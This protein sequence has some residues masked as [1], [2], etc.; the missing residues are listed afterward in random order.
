MNPEKVIVPDR[1]A[2]GAFS[3]DRRQFLK[4]LGGGI[5]ICFTP[6]LPNL[7]NETLAAGPG[8]LPKD[9]NA[10]LRINEDGR[11]TLF[12]GKIEMGQGII[13]SLAQMLAEE[14]DVP[15]SSVDMVMGDTDLCPWDAGTYGSMSTK[16]F[17][18]PLRD[19]AAEARQIL[20]LL[21]SQ[22]L[23]VP[24]DRLETRA[25]S[26]VDKQAPKRGVTYGAL[27]KGKRIEKHLDG[28]PLLKPWTEFT[29]S[30]KPTKRTDAVAKVTGQA[31]FT[32]DFTF[33]GMLYAKILRPPV[34]GAK[35]MD[36]DTSAA[37]KIPGAR[38]VRDRD[39]VAALHATP[40]GAETAL[41]EVM[42]KFS[43]PKTGWNDGNI[44]EKLLPKAPPGVVVGEAG[45]L[46]QGRKLASKVIEAIYRQGY[47]AHAPIE[48]QAAVATIE[49][50]RLKIWASTQRPF[51]ATEEVAQALGISPEKVH[52]VTPFVG[53]AFGGK[54]R[55]KQVVEAARLAKLTGRPVQVAWSRAEEFF[56]DYFQPAAIVKIAS[57]LDA[58]NR[59]VFWDYHVY[60][61]GGDKAHTFYDIPNTKTLSYGDW[62]QNPGI[63]PFETGPWRGPNGNTN[64]FARESHMDTVAAAIGEDPLAFRLRHLKNDR[65]R[66]VLEAAASKFGWSSGK[67]PSGTGR[68][69][70]CVVYKGTCVAAMGEIEVDKST[71][72]CRM[73]RV[74]CAQDMGRVINP[75][76]AQMQMEGCI[77]MG[78]GYALTEVVRFR[79]GEILDRNFDTY[80]LPRF[81]A[82]PKI[83]TV[84]V[85]NR[86]MQPQEGG[87]PAITCM[88][89][90]VANAVYDA[91]G[92]RFDMLPISRDRVKEAL[93]KRG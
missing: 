41:N 50:D 77:M 59:L 27:T 72:Q 49:D 19:A 60:F 48:T 92:V 12:T 20:V 13:T 66:R 88:G 82:M 26:V 3:L 28:K 45:N 57:G 5:I 38:I 68:G 30:G 36:V 37:E 7:A 42:A 29:V 61:A 69:L 52:I 64:T 76:G 22:R 39:F 21:A 18:P 89:G 67:A 70:A 53:G 73:K 14:L 87:E 55:N 31:K 56:N 2:V 43:R 85:D 4:I 1:E 17:G 81:S 34:H 78:L 86:D 32:A 90:L 10:F 71:G 63:H 35:L 93:S 80:E 84:L 15:L 51:G 24:P 75:E 6:V 74:V 44:F 33:P 47:V 25:G 16:F 62:R 54:E 46:D 11:V 23:N 9:F 83:E 58:S 91:I 65:V 79:D 40:D 8:E